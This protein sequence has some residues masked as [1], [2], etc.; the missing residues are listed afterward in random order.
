MPI[1]II[2]CIYDLADGGTQEDYATFEKK[3]R[4]NILLVCSCIN[5]GSKQNGRIPEI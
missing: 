3:Q 5:I 2:R 4:K 1:G